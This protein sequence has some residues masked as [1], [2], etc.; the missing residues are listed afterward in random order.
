M[1]RASLKKCMEGSFKSGT[2]CQDELVP[3]GIVPV[4][5]AICRAQFHELGG[6]SCQQCRRILC[7]RHFIRGFLKGRGALC[8][9]C[10]KKN[11]SANNKP[12][13]SPKLKFF[14]PN[15]PQKWYS[16][17]YIFYPT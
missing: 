17:A 8:S 13:E 12:K 15:C 4:T 9:E 6:A 14:F 10:L 11:S 16:T 5:C 3:V 7:R 2:E 1:A